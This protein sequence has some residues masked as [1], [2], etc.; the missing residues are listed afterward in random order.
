MRTSR[1]SAPAGRPARAAV[2]AGTAPGNLS[3]WS[4]LRGMVRAEVTWNPSRAVGDGSPGWGETTLSAHGRGHRCAAMLLRS[5]C[6]A[7]TAPA[8]PLVRWSAVV[9]PISAPRAHPHYAPTQVTTGLRRRERDVTL[10]A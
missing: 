8:A 2:V 3:P 5:G 4:S 7:G 1:S 10:H 9:V 6:S